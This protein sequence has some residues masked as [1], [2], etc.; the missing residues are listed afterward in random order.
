MCIETKTC[1]ESHMDSV[2]ALKE[3]GSLQQK[4][5]IETE[6]NARDSSWN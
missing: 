1:Y 6:K 2:F 3:A 5:C 4:I